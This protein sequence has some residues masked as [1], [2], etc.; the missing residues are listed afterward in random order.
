MRSSSVPLAKRAKCDASAELNC[1]PIQVDSESDSEESLV[2]VW[3]E[4]AT[5][6]PKLMYVAKPPHGQTML[7]FESYK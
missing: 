6:I 2:S 7:S 1:E 4:V 5:L 3:A